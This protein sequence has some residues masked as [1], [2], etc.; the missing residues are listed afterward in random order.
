LRGAFME[1]WEANGGMSVLGPPISNAM[2]RGATRVQ[3]TRY[4]RLEQPG[5]ETT[6]RAGKCGRRVPATARHSVPL[7]LTCAENR[8][9]RDGEPRQ[10]IPALQRIAG[11]QHLHLT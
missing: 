5:G 8:P 9:D 7:A 4:A 10:H 3:Y 11:A 2:L 1:A 6:R